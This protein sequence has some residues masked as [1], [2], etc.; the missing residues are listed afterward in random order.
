MRLGLDWGRRASERMIARDCTA[1]GSSGRVALG[2]PREVCGVHFTQGHF[3]KTLIR[4][5]CTRLRRVAC[6]R[7]CSCPTTSAKR[8]CKAFGIAA[9]LVRRCSR[10]WWSNGEGGV[11][12]GRFPLPWPYCGTVTEAVYCL[13][14]TRRLF[15]PASVHA[16]LLSQH[17]CAVPHVRRGCAR[18]LGVLDG[19]AWL[20]CQARVHRRALQGAGIKFLQRKLTAR[21][22]EADAHG[23]LGKIGYVEAVRRRCRGASSSLASRPTTAP[24][25]PTLCCSRRYQ[26]TDVDCCT[27]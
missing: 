24:D 16:N 25:P 3:P 6:G 5:R 22:R 20:M 13:L 15:W 19:H 1:N 26:H 11:S 2:S 27:S 8:F 9:A 14:F 10:W 17:K 12:T 18:K 4:R 21:Q 23:P 7:P